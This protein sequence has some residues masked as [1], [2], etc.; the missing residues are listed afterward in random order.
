MFAKVFFLFKKHFV[1]ESLLGYFYSISYFAR[2]IWI[3]AHLT[4]PGM[5]DMSWLFCV[6]CLSNGYIKVIYSYI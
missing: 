6:E 3:F 1:R 5:Y 2:K 4:I